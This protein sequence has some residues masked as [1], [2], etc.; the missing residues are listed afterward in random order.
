[1]VC[2]ERCSNPWK[3][4]G[5]VASTYVENYLH[6]STIEMLSKKGVRLTA[7]GTCVG[8]YELKNVMEPVHT[9]DMAGIID[10]R[11]GSEHIVTI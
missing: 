3:R 7:C 10:E 6:S 8:H 1:M 4:D 11:M 2:R 5:D 9:G